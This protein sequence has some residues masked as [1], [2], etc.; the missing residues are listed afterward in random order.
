ME[1]RLPE[2]VANDC[3]E[4]ISPV[5]FFGL[6]DAAQQRFY[7]EDLEVLSR[8]ESDLQLLRFGTSA[9]RADVLSPDV[10]HREIFEAAALGRKV[11]DINR[12]RSNE[13]ASFDRENPDHSVGIRQR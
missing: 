6:K 2:V 3:F 9:G 5:V 13:R 8:N 12:R 10:I 1:A 4:L 11:A 7:G